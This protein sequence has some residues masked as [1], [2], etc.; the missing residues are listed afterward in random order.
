MPGKHVQTSINA[1]AKKPLHRA[2]RGLF[3]KPQKSAYDQMV[4]EYQD[5]IRQAE[6]ERIIQKLR[7]RT[8][9]HNPILEMHID[10]VEELIKGEQ[11][12]N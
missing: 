11:N 3:M 2:K 12:G 5:S 10:D 6:R 7:A 1:R 4:H 8:T 9:K